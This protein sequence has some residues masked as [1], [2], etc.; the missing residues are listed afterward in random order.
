MDV[1]RVREHLV[2][3]GASGVV[4]ADRVHSPDPGH[5]RRVVHRDKGRRRHGRPR[6]RPR[7]SPSA[8]RTGGRRPGPARSCRRRPAAAGRCAARVLHE[9]G[10]AVAAKGP[11]AA[12][13]ASRSS[14][15]PGRTCTGIRSGASSSRTR[16]YSAGAPWWA[17]SPVTTTASGADRGR[18]RPRR[19]PPACGRGSRSPAPTWM[20]RSLICARRV[21][22]SVLMGRREPTVG[23]GRD[24]PKWRHTAR[25][26]LRRRVGRGARAGRVVQGSRARLGQPAPS[27]MPAGRGE[28]DGHHPGPQRRQDVVVDPVADVGDLGRGEIGQLRDRGK[29][30]RRRLGRTKAGRRGDEVRGA[31]GAQEPLASRRSC[32]PATPTT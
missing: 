25:R 19:P 8:R 28:V 23:R 30:L 22:S 2:E 6:A 1:R 11:S 4:E 29:E 18:P 5:E 17:R 27:E 32:C 12:R 20:W 31:G 14:W 16:S 3:L 26:E 10:R 7:A 13:S 21:R 9:R 24:A 15:F